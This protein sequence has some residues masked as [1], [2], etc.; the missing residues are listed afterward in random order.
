MIRA[1]AAAAIV[2]AALAIASC[3]S[4]GDV[5]PEAAPKA[6]VGPLP[7][8]IVARVG[9]SVIHGESVGR[10]AA[11]Q[12]VDVQAARD[13]AV[14]DALF[15]GGAEARHLDVTADVRSVLA[16]RFL[17]SIRAE[18]E[19]TPPSAEE[20][21]EAAAAREQRLGIPRALIA[22]ELLE[23]DIFNT[24]AHA[25]IAQLL[26]QRQPQIERAADADALLALV[27]VER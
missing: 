4:R 8:G 18:V 22:P 13:L 16:R 27:H 24:R 17:R 11:L 1:R 5:P 25:A 20:L 6:A 12:H 2:T 7:E 26:A 10:I 15:A 23:A 14:R 9:P 21:T 19:R 3:S